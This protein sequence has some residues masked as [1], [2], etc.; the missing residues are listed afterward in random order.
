MTEPT[1]EIIHVEPR[2]AS[3]MLWPLPKP[4]REDHGPKQETARI[5][6]LPGPVESSSV[7]PAVI[8]SQ[9][10][11][12]IETIPR[13]LCWALVGISAVIFLIQIWNYVVS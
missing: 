11:V 1:E 4:P 10:P 13:A 12:P 5:N 7:G 2:P 3:P 6:I 9:P 8:T